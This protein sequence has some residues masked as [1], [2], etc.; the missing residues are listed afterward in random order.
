MSDR[1]RVPKSEAEERFL[2]SRVVPKS[3]QYNTKWPRG[4]KVFEE[5]QQKRKNKVAEEEL[6]GLD[7]FDFANVEDLTVGIEHMSVHS[8]NFWLCK[9]IC[10]PK[11]PSKMAIDIRLRRCYN[12]LVCAINRHLNELRGE[13]L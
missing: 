11:L 8:I 9:F 4:V 2:V 10:E 3:I 12:L 6:V 1:F 13:K 7:G 5:W